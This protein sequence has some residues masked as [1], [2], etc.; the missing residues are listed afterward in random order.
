MTKRWDDSSWTF[1][2]NHGAV[3]YAIM[4][5]GTL[6][7]RH[8]AQRVGITERRAA[9]IIKDLREAGYLQVERTGRRCHYQVIRDRSL[10]RFPLENVPLGDF[11]LALR[12]AG[13]ATATA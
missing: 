10:Q 13:E 3:L 11:L 7:V 8:L 5:D 2:T 9:Q 6:T 1:I 12:Q 4:E